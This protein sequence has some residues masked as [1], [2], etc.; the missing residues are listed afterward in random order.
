MLATE[1]HN[2]RQKNKQWTTKEKEN[3][4]E[5][6]CCVQLRLRVQQAC[7]NAFEWLSQ[8]YNFHEFDEYIRTCD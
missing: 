4:A 6:G 8:T 1:S 5:N 7:N 2:L 3:Y